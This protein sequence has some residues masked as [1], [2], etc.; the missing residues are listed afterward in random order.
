M[1][2]VAEIIR[3]TPEG[4]KPARQI[5]DGEAWLSD[6]LARARDKVVC[7]PVILSPSRAA[8]LMARNAEN[9]T[10][11][12][13]LVDL[14]AA[15]ILNGHWQFNGETIIVADTGEL[16]DGQHRC[17]AVIDSGEAVETMLVAGVPRRARMTTDQGRARKVSDFA[18]MSGMKYAALSSSVASNLLVIEKYGAIPRGYRVG[19]D[20]AG[21]TTRQEV[22]E[23][24]R[25]HLSEIESAV[26]F[27]LRL[28][29]AISVVGSPTRFAVAYIIICRACVDTPTVARFF[30]K[31]GSGEG[32]SKQDAVWQVR[33]RLISDRQAQ[34]QT[35]FKFMEAVIK[36]WNSER[37]GARGSRLMLNGTWP[38]IM[39]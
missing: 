8:A 21:T 32:I 9:R 2:G 23:Y 12:K 38:K 37:S 6:L 29:K 26:E 39:G 30:E 31:L 1:Y 25:R 3:K 24:G 7:E 11:S 20:R 15:D 22:L 16:N 34:S 4:F 27:V 33:E 14:L 18:H 36:G 28:G 19:G 17:Q 35:P 10:L 5:D 13:K